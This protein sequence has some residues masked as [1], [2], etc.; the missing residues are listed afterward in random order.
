MAVW[1]SL[2][3]FRLK[4]E[5]FFDEKDRNTSFAHGIFSNCHLLGFIARVISSA[6]IVDSFFCSFLWIRNFISVGSCLFQNP[7]VHSCLVSSPSVMVAT[8]H[9]ANCC[10]GPVYVPEESIAQP[11]T[12]NAHVMPLPFVL[13]CSLSWACLGL[14]RSWVP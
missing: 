6:M 10:C 11:E 1:H 8:S 7:F 5:I 12:W 3:L 4:S 13:G 14:Y 9:I 2:G